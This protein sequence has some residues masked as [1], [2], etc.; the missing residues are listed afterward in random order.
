MDKIA[1][2]IKN[3]S[4]YMIN[5]AAESAAKQIRQQIGRELLQ[6]IDMLLYE[7]CFVNKGN[8]N[9]LVNYGIGMSIPAVRE[10]CQLGEEE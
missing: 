8:P 4:S 10:V 3:H 5:G 2:I 9:G 1:E 7:E 6:Q